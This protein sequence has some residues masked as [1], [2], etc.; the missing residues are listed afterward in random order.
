[1]ALHSNPRHHNLPAPLSTFIGR[2]T[3]VAEVKKRLSAQRLLTLTGPGGCGKTRLAIRVASDLTAAYTDGVWLV[4][5]APLADAMLVPQAVASALGVNEQAGSTLIEALSDHLLHRRTLLVLDNCEHLVVACARLVETLLQACPGLRILATSR[6]NL[7]IPGETVW[8]VPPLSLPEPQPWRDPSSRQNAL[9]AYKQS[10]AVQLFVVRAAAALPA[11]AL[12]EQNGAWVAEVCH[13]LDGMPLAIELAAARVQ[14]LSI[15]QI[16]ERLDDR[17]HLLTSGSRTA[18]TRQQTLEATL[19]W[20]FS[21]LTETEQSV[22]LRL[23]VFA[24]GWTLEAAE[25]ICLG[26]GTEARDVLDLLTQLANKS[27]VVVERVPGQETRFRLLET[28][29]QYARDKM[30]AAGEAGEGQARHRDWYMNLAGQADSELRGPGQSAWIERLEREHDNFRAALAWSLENDATGALQLA[31]RLG[32]FWFMRGHH[33]GE[34]IEW[35]VR[36]LSQAE[37]PEQAV[38]RASA[39][40]WLGVLTYIQGDYGAARSAHERSLALYQ[41]LQDRDGIAEA[42]Y[43]LAD[44]AALQGDAVAARSLYAQAGSFSADSLTSLREQG[45]KWNVARTLNYLGELARVEGD[46]AAARSF[47][48]ESLLIRHELGDQRGMAVSLHNIGFV[49]HHQGDYRQAVTFF[50]E[51]LSLFQKLGSWRGVVDCLLGLAG[52]AV[53]AGQPERAARLF[54]A[55]EAVREAIYVGSVLSYPDRVEYDRY[56][57]AVRAQLDEAAFA[58][59]WAEGRELTLEQAI[60][61]ALSE[62]P[63]DASTPPSAQ[64]LKEKFGGLT[65]REREVATLIA[66]GKSNREIAEAM[67]V[68]LKTAETYM[69]RI[70]N[71]LG[72]D[73]R[74][75]IALWAIEKGLVPPTQSLDS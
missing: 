32:Q 12:T 23:S 9:L 47:Y 67:S 48:E 59:A 36:V 6:E 2:E 56:V 68:G 11:F 70:R 27:L 72:F 63:A 55:T 58:A 71:K 30:Q 41:E 54:G 51:S 24:G 37:A 66:Q 74:V 60:E 34:G 42:F 25:A 62:I 8:S 31:E 29:R 45:D 75:Q 49:T 52:A 21:L 20:S 10:E 73:S 65:R 7:G 50:V 46:Y 26:H 4:E 57:A 22:L 28:I 18:P 33:F 40:H 15:Q 17:F 19:D 39:F 13:K 35:L 44:A 5:F 3:E 14:T 16:A 64:E 1:V 69:T 61:Y 43:Y 53:S 38:T